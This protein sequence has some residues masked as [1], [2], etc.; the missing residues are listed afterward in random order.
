MLNNAA[1]IA[2]MVNV[3]KTKTLSVQEKTDKMPFFIN[4]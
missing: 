4:S 2:L 3:N 1:R